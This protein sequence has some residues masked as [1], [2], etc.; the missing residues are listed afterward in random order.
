MTAPHFFNCYPDLA[1]QIEGMNPDRDLHDT[2]VDIEPYLG[3]SMSIH[4][5]V[6]VIIIG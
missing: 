1:M 3:I 2:T 6:Q 4:K 5:R